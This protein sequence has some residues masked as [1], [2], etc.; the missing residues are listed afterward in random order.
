MA[1]SCSSICRWH[2]SRRSRD[3]CPAH[4]KAGGNPAFSSRAELRLF[5]FLQSLLRFLQLGFL[6]ADLRLALLDL[7]LQAFCCLLRHGFSL[8]M[9]YSKCE[10][11]VYPVSS[12]PIYQHAFA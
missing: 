7:F 12:N 9:G 3:I 10:W 1:V 5:G 2:C 4:K 6:L 8:L 11:I